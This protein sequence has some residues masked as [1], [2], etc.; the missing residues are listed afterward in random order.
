[1]RPLRFLL[2]L[3]LVIAGKTLSAQDTIYRVNREMILAKVT[4]VGQYDIRYKRASNLEGPAYTI[5]KTEVWKIVYANG[6]TD[7]FNA[8]HNVRGAY[9]PEHT[10]R[11]AMIGI[12]SF[13]LL[14]GVV[15]LEGE[16][17]VSNELAL[18]VPLSFG[19]SALAGADPS[20]D[21]FYYYSRDKIFSTGLKALF[22]PAGQNHI[23]NYYLGVAGEYGVVRNLSYS[24]GYP[25]PQPSPVIS[26]HWYIGTGIVNGVQLQASEHIFINLD[27]VFGMNVSDYIN[28]TYRPMGRLGITMGYRF[29]KVPPAPVAPGKK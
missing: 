27:V 28:S 21:Y 6:Q 10:P 9:D 26:R 20:T 14:F 22:F 8:P 29:G 18:R 3:F 12:N 17:N 13:D 2:L 16:Y 5:R 15:T 4:E 1:M 7:Y 11:P 25:Y 23:A 24:Y 19:V